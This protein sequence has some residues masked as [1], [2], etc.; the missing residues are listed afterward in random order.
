MSTIIESNP[1][2]E[3]RHHMASAENLDIMSRH[4]KAFDEAEGRDLSRQESNA[5]LE[6]H[7]LLRSWRAK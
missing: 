1:E 2:L 3:I 5:V 4:Q 6:Q 7:G